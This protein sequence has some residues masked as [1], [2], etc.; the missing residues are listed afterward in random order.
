MFAFDPSQKLMGP[1][2]QYQAQ[3]Q[4]NSPSQAGAGEDFF[5]HLLDVVNPLQHL[6][7]VGTIYRAVTGEHIGAVEKVAG[8]ALYGGVWGAASSLAD[9]TFEAITGKSVE[10]TV[11]AW[12]KGDDNGTVQ[13]AAQNVQAPQIA[14]NAS[15]PDADMPELPVTVAG[16]PR[17]DSTELAA[18]S[19]A[20][21]AKGVDGAIAAR[22]LYAYGR[23]VG[24]SAP[25]VASLN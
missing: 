23:M 17:R 19:G 20:L 13:F 14:A 25:V 11:L 6:P 9:V 16:L 12:F 24:A 10:D 2:V 18:L 4:G 1:R 7:V 21:N 5:H 3:D 15:L 22:A 8:D